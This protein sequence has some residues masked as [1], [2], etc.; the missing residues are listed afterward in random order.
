[1]ILA[2]GLG[3]PSGVSRLALILVATAL[4]AGCQ[5]A[6]RAAPPAVPLSRDGGWQVVERLGDA[7]YRAASG[8]WSPT[9]PAIRLPDG[10]L[11]T[12]GAGGRLILARPGEHLTAGPASRFALPDAAPGAPLQQRAGRL[13]YRVAGPPAGELRLATPA[14][15]IEAAQAVFDVTVGTDATEV[16]VQE[17]RLRLGTAD[18]LRQIELGPGQSAY[19]ASGESLAFR[20]TASAPLESVE[21][22]VLPAMQPQA[23]A[24]ESRAETPAR[25][26]E[27]AGSQASTSGSAASSAAVPIGRAAVT[28]IAA[29]GAVTSEAPRYAPEAV[30]PA[31]PAPRTT[32]K[33]ITGAPLVG[34]GPAPVA[35][36]GRDALASPE[37]AGS[38]VARQEPGDRVPEDPQPGPFDRLSEGMVN[39]VPGAA[40]ERRRATDAHRSF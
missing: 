30:R 15:E 32:V 26:T 34:P 2:K 11:V 10:S 25:A 35:E 24:R 33:A 17:G 4:A 28:L 9:L 12:T 21:A 40:M 39:G 23:E 18:G 27:Y 13:R 31:P 14:V 38:A 3:P 37:A 22:L 6:G 8:D 36:N 19:A 5:S 16:A 29:T 1:M 7:R 20:R